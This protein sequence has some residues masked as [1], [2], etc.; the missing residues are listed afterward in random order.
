MKTGGSTR[1]WRAAHPR[2]RGEHFQTA[3]NIIGDIGSSPL[4]RGTSTQRAGRR[5]RFRLIPA[6]AGNIFMASRHSGRHSAHPRSRGEHPRSSAAASC[7]AGSSPLARGTSLL[8]LNRIA[9][10]RLIPARAGNMAWR[11]LRRILATAHPRSRG[12]H[13]Q[14]MKMRYAPAGSS[15]LARGTSILAI[16]GERFI[17][18]IPARAGNI[19]SAGWRE[20][21]GA[22]H[23]R[24]RGE[25]NGIVSMRAPKYGSSPL[26]RGT[27]P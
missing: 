26:A 18:L 16:P 17:R 10:A 2:S 14:N 12:E 21:G 19:S 25:H 22:A 6:R 8:T 11:V 1:R 13:S 20:R 5:L 24:S 4:A 23:P 7:C 15:P 27:S 3:S 9:R